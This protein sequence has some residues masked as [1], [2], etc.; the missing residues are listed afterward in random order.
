M[1][2]DQLRPDDAAIRR[3]LAECMTLVDI[4]DA[5]GWAPGTARRRRWRSAEQGGLPNADAEIGGVALWFRRTIEEW[6]SRPRQAARG[7]GRPRGGDIAVTATDPPAAEPADLPDE[8]PEPPSPPAPEPR[9]ALPP[10]DVPAAATPEPVAAA[11]R[12]AEQDAPPLVPVDDL[13]EVASGLDL[14]V[15]QTVIAE[16]RGAWREAVVTHRDRTTVL[17]EYQLDPA[18]LGARGQRVGIDRVRLPPDG[19]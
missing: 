6:G 14:A 3:A 17:V 2:A 19:R 5:M 4:D 1:P 9:T 15:G 8:H 13:A 10:P 12:P 16:V 11:E 18:P 7:R